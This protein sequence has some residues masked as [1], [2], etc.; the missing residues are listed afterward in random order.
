MGPD[1]HELV[2]SIKSVLRSDEKLMAEAI[3]SATF[4]EQVYLL[5]VFI[6]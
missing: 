5:L 2:E 4:L 3:T 1:I 6:R